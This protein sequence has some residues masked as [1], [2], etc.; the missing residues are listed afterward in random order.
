MKIDIFYESKSGFR[1]NV[2]AINLGRHNRQII[3]VRNEHLESDSIV[4]LSVKFRIPYARHYNPLLI[5]NR[6]CIQTADFRLKK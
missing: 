4:E 2:P 1:Q 5:S 6:S 3:D